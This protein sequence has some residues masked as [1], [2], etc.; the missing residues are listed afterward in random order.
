M[1]RAAYDVAASDRRTVAAEAIVVVVHCSCAA[2]AAAVAA[3]RRAVTAED[4][5]ACAERQ[6]GRVAG[7]LA[8]V[9]ASVVRR[10]VDHCR[11]VVEDLADGPGAVAASIVAVDRLDA[12]HA[13]VDHR[14]VA[15]AAA[16]GEAFH[17]AVVVAAAV[18][19]VARRDVDQRFECDVAAVATDRRH[20]GRVVAHLQSWVVRAE[21]PAAV[22]ADPGVQTYAAAAVVV[23]Y[24]RDCEVKRAVPDS[25]MAVPWDWVPAAEASDCF[26][27]MVKP[28]WVGSVAVCDSIH[29]TFN[30]ISDEYFTHNT[31]H[32][33]ASV[34]VNQPFATKWPL[35][36]TI[37]QHTPNVHTDTK[38]TFQ[39]IRPKFAQTIHI[40]VRLAGW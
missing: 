7:D 12:V 25:G 24:C 6:D 2:A 31:A 26:V 30:G 27:V 4:P 18:V 22:A 35:V 28:L 10:D 11:R 13:L 37:H 32:C 16:D 23:R 29:C 8:C 14:A 36:L 33:F 1:V 34:V 5:A 15:V 19:V 17:L 39:M 9:A 21:G 20:C 3:D 38:P 40:Y